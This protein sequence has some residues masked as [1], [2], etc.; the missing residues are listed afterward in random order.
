MREDSQ[1]SDRPSPGGAPVKLQPPPRIGRPPAH[2][3][4]R[5]S[6]RRGAAFWVTAVGFVVLAAAAVAV[7]T[8]LPGW[9][10]KREAS[11][12]ETTAPPP[13]AVEAPAPPAESVAPLPPPTPRPEAPPPPRAEPPERAPARAASPDPF[14][15]AMSE[16]LD[17]LDRGDHATARTAFERALAE[18]PGESQARDGLAQAETGLRLEAIAELQER[19][20]AAEEAEDWPTTE[21]RY[22]AILGLDPTVAFAREGRERAQRRKELDERLAY[23]L[24]NSERLASADVREEVSALAERARGLENPGPR[25]ADQLA[26]L[27]ALIEAYS[28]PVPAVLL[29]DGATEVTIYKVGR[30]GT[31]DRREL[32]L[33]PGTYT[34]VGSRRGYRDVRHE[35]A[36]E[37]GTP[38]EPLVVRCEEAI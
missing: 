4:V 12:S 9:I 2:G 16:G 19:A 7:F 24:Q 21:A 23:H 11:P 33:R 32:E 37:P 15:E 26:R 6:S 5:S 1:G 13:A 10:A 22:A 38:P 25:L 14:V 18:R 34:V 30:L 8:F 29:S 31:F 17:A 36:I 28:I 20:L 3:A 27:D 35:L